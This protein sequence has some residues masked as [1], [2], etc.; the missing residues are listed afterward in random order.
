MLLVLLEEKDSRVLLQDSKLSICKRRPTEVTEKLDVSE[1]GIQPVF[2][3]QSPEPVR[4][5]ITTE[6]KLTRKYTESLTELTREAP[7]QISI[8]PINQSHL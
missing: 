4:W 2:F 1:L 5:D 6:Q 7:P 3:G 8:S